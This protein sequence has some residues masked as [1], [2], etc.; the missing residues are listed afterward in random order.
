MRYR[1]RLAL[2]LV[3][4]GLS[5]GLRAHDSI[6]LNGHRL[7][8]RGQSLQTVRALTSATADAEEGS[9]V[10][11]QMSRQVTSR[12]IDELAQQGVKLGDYLGN[13]TYHAL[14][15]KQHARPSRMRRGTIKAIVPLRSEWKVD[16]A[17]T[18]RGGN[19][20]DADLEELLPV[21]IYLAPNA[22]ATHVERMLQEAGCRHVHLNLSL[23]TA[24]AVLPASRLAYVAD[25]P[26][27]LR[28]APADRPNSADNYGGRTLGCGYALSIPATWGGRGLSGKGIRIGVWDANIVSH[29]ELDGRFA[30]QESEIGGDGS[31]RHATH[32][33]GSVLGNG[34]I[35][36]EAQ[37]VAPQAQAWTYNFNTQRNGK[38]EP[39][40]M[41]EARRQFGITLTQNSYG[42][43]LRTSCP[44]YRQFRYR[45]ADYE[46]DRLAHLHPTLTHVLAAGND[47]GSCQ[48]Q[49]QSQHGHPLYG[50]TA[51]RAK[52]VIYV[53]ATDA[54]GVLA[55]F[56][57]CGP[58]DDGRLFPTVVARGVGVL[59]T[60]P[61]GTHRTM[62]GT[63]MACPLVTGHLALLQERYQQL[64]R[65]AEIRSDLLRAVV[66]NTADDAGRP[67]PDF[68]YGY[69][70][71]NAER[72]ARA[73]ES[74]YYTMGK[75]GHKE[76]TTLTL[77][78]PR[79]CSGLRVMLAWNDAASSK[80]VA[81][82]SPVLINDLDMQVLVDRTPYHP[83]V[84][85]HQK[86][87]VE[88]V[89][90]RRVDRLNNQEQITITRDELR[91]AHEVTI[92]IAGRKVVDGQQTYALT[93]WF[94]DDSPRII[95]PGAGAQLC[96]GEKYVARM[97]GSSAWY[98]AWI[99][100]DDGAHYESLGRI[101]GGGSPPGTSPAFTVP[102]NAPTCRTAR[103]KMID[104]RGQEAVSAQPFIIA[105]QVEEPQLISQECG[106]NGWLLRWNG[107]NEAQHGYEVLMAE[108]REGLY[109]SVGH[110]AHAHDVQFDIPAA[111]AQRY[112]HPVFSIAVR[113]PGGGWGKRSQGVLAPEP[114]ALALTGEALPFLEAFV[115]VPSPHFRLTLGDKLQAGYQSN[116]QS[117]ILGA[118]QLILRSLESVQGAAPADH[119]DKGQ[120]GTHLAELRLCQVDLRGIA[121]QE[122]L[123]L[124]MVGQLGS[125]SPKTQ[126]ASR[127]RMLVNGQPVADQFGTVDHTASDGRTNEFLFPLTGGE[128][129][130]LAIQFAGTA[131]GTSFTLSTIAIERVADRPDVSLAALTVPRE[132]SHLG[133]IEGTVRLSNEN[134][135]P[136][137]NI[138]IRCEVDGEWQWGQSIDE[139][140]GKETRTIV[141]PIELGAPPTLGALRRI[142]MTATLEGDTDAQNNAAEATVNEMGDVLTIP[143]SHSE[144]VNGKRVTHDPRRIHVVDGPLMFTDDGGAYGPHSALQISTLKLVPKDPSMRVRIQFTRFRSYP[145]QGTLA[146]YTGGVGDNLS[147][148]GL[149]PRV[150]LSGRHHPMPVTYVSEANDGG[151]T[152][153][154]RSNLSTDEGW[155][156]AVDLVPREN[157]LALID[158]KAQLRG[159]T[160][161][162]EVPIE[163]TVLN[164]WPEAIKGA[165]LI[166][167]DGRQAVAQ[168]QIP[169]LAS[170]R[171]RIVFD[172]K[173][174]MA[175]GS[176]RL[177]TLLLRGEDYDE[178]DN[179]LPLLAAYDRYCLPGPIAKSDA[180]A[181][182]QL[183]L[184]GQQLPMPPAMGHM[185]YHL[186]QRFTVYRTKGA[187]PLAVQLTQRAPANSALGVW[188]DWNDDG[189][190][191]TDEGVIN[192]I[193]PQAD[194]ASVAIDP[195]RWDATGVRRMRIAVGSETELK[196]EPCFAQGLT[197][198]DIRDV[199]LVIEEEPPHAPDDLELT[200]VDAGK[201]GRN[202]SAAQPITIWVRNN[203]DRPYDGTIR[204]VASVDGRKLAEEVIDCTGNPIAANGAEVEYRLQGTADLSAVGRHRLEVVIDEVD[205]KAQKGNNIRS[206]DVHCLRGEANGFYAL[207]MRSLAQET[208]RVDMHEVARRIPR[209]KRGE[210]YTV[211]LLLMLDKA[212]AATLIDSKGF[213]LYTQ[214]GGGSTSSPCR[215]ALNVGGGT[216]LST[217]TEVLTPGRWHHVAVVMRDI[218]P[219]TPAPS[220]TPGSCLVDVYVDGA[221]C[222]LTNQMGREPRL[223]ELQLGSKLDGKLDEFRLWH[224]AVDE[225]ELQ[226]HVHAHWRNPAGELPAGCLMEFSIDEGPGNSISMSGEDVAYIVAGDDEAIRAKT[227]GVWFDAKELISSIR[228]TGQVGEAQQDERNV[229]TVRFPKGTD[230]GHITG[231]V[232]A[233]WPNSSL[234]YRGKPV[235]PSNPFDFNETV[236]IT[237]SHAAIFGQSLLQDVELRFA[238][239]PLDGCELLELRL[240][241]AH[242]PWLTG[243]DVT[244]PIQPRM[245]IAL[246]TTPV[247][248]ELA[249]GVVLTFR[250]SEDAVLLYGDKEYQD[251]QIAVDLREETKLT[252]RAANGTIKTYRLRLAAQQQLEWRL[253]STEFV[254]GDV[255]GKVLAASESG[256]II[257]FTSSNPAVASVANDSLRIG[258]CGT[259]IITAQQRGGGFHGPSN[260]VSHTITVRKRSIQVY[261]AVQP[262]PFGEPVE[263]RF[264]YKTLVSPADAYAL[265]DPMAMGIYKLIDSHGEEVGLSPLLS[266]GTYELKVAKSEAYESTQY[267]ITPKGGTITIEQGAKRL[268]RLT[269][270]NEQGNAIEGAT[271]RI[272]AHRLQSDRKGE[273][274]VALTDGQKYALMVEHPG[275]MTVRD[276]LNVAEDSDTHQRI[277]LRATTIRLEY[278]SGSHGRIAGDRIQHVAAGSNG[279]PVL[280]QADDGYHFARW[281]DGVTD[282][283]RADRQVEQAVHVRAQFEPNRHRLHYS[284]H[285]GGQWI[286]GAPQQNV[287]HGANGDP[288]EVGAQDG[289]YFFAEWSDGALNALRQELNVQHDIDAA[290][291]FG[292]YAT[293]PEVQQ[294]ATELVDGGWY[295]T[296]HGAS[297]TGWTVQPTLPE[298]GYH[299]SGPLAVCQAGNAEK[300]NAGNITTAQ[301]YTPRYRLASTANNIETRCAYLF[302]RTGNETLALEYTVDGSTWV[303]LGD[304]FTAGHN[305]AKTVERTVNSSALAGAVFIQF[306]WTYRFAGQGGYAAISRAYFYESASTRHRYTYVAE[307][308]EGGKFV[309]NGEEVQ[310]QDVAHGQYPQDVQAVA[311][312]GFRFG[313]WVGQKGGATLSPRKPA[314][315]EA[316]YTARFL[317]V[318]L[319]RVQYRAS[320]AEGGHF[321]MAG[322]PVTEQLV[323][324]G[325]LSH[326]VVAV[327]HPG[328]HFV[329]WGD[330]GETNPSRGRMAIQS[331]VTLDGLFV[332]NSHQLVI[333]V[334]RQNE[335]VED[336]TVAIGIAQRTGKDGR[337]LFSLPSGRYAYSVA[338]S[339]RTVHSG[340]V[341]LEDEDTHLRVNLNDGSTIPLRRIIFRVTNGEAPLPHTHVT[342]GG[343][344]LE[345]DE[346]GETQWSLPD[347]TYSYT[348]R[349]DGY[350]D[351]SGTVELKG[352]N[353]RIDIALAVVSYELQYKEPQHVYLSVVDADGHA[354]PSGSR[355]T[356]GT[357]L[358]MT[359]ETDVG[360]RLASL[361]VNGVDRYA[362]LGQD[363]TFSFRMMEATTIETE[364]GRQAGYFPVTI[365]PARGGTIEVRHGRSLVQDGDLL[366]LGATIRIAL[367]PEAG[368][369][370]SGLS[371]NG[372]DRLELVAEGVLQYQIVG[373]SE[374]AAE[375]KRDVPSSAERTEAEGFT[376]SPNPF[377]GTLYVYVPHQE[378]QIRLI[379]AHGV[380]VHEQASQGSHRVALNL[381]CL[382]AGLYLV[383][384][385]GDGFHRCIPVMK[386]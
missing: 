170:G 148:S 285:R 190:F 334:V 258:R 162:G 119:Y 182:G 65:G 237:A 41:D 293:L 268:V 304:E 256:R 97:E 185:Q 201:D 264:Q 306:R 357:L 100:Y 82:G 127:F 3:L 354:R 379:N 247:S 152:L 211:E 245:V 76:S 372:I 195:S 46:M 250:M 310:H 11:V 365:L 73:L 130:S 157:P 40:E 331:D 188:V 337:A 158:G 151:I 109:E 287:E 124:R 205:A 313:E 60:T 52:N 246:P 159:R 352:R 55:P 154:F 240:E 251:G 85:Q 367:T 383:V 28:I 283:P 86:G 163:A 232:L 386:R 83:W 8:L 296:S 184:N 68:Q 312:P 63:S 16:T 311:N 15:R 329:R 236:R 361:R 74:G 300:T 336:V 227:G 282:N 191:S 99:S 132:G 269:V 175:L 18:A 128:E 260:P 126:S 125:I 292:G 51:L 1:Y 255:G 326:E 279:A 384:I 174:R 375:F 167:W 235:G 254:Y 101:P 214:T 238:T 120:N 226:A 141:V 276:E 206:T 96:P 54:Q 129:V 103:L 84:C 98:D 87:Q 278:E 61:L 267:I 213:K 21:A 35:N 317:P 239:I 349:R 366:P 346:Q 347:G 252:V 194:N 93:W 62:D 219:G 381:G 378:A 218:V 6:M 94:D 88:A 248:E 202:L 234:L 294:F 161:Q 14:L 273:V 108:A 220:S 350:T 323:R 315:T 228:L 136:A 31:E 222:A 36:P 133:R 233:T 178:Q 286:A 4:L 90:S 225:A 374:I 149:T 318:D 113:T 373:A 274:T 212:Q 307:P 137:K 72:A 32:V 321:E 351:Q 364:S 371:V 155:I 81:Y 169:E 79:E 123:Q 335:P 291:I 215:L 244:V 284:V 295:A 29:P 179:R 122:P 243:G 131:S 217:Q 262:T 19:P 341:V 333:E 187:T 180:L 143:R 164:R 322:T 348:V 231:E 362:E 249:K 208:Q 330:N 263:W 376:A 106:R 259:C 281:D 53:G 280:A 192:P 319:F 181:I 353:A 145:L 221:R 176:N 112:A 270:V 69:G 12:E 160:S 59:S 369:K 356:H 17:L 229:Y 34:V 165:S 156:A 343:Q 359:T 7:A 2:L 289:G 56:S 200:R 265:P 42:P 78:V 275:H 324:A 37:G 316:R 332:R 118:N 196:G 30:R 71:L 302:K 39:Q 5:V 139:L 33:L 57:S 105:P 363:G 241:Q 67:G 138:R 173:L 142:R 288:V 338:D 64:H 320:A 382:P 10:L 305:S 345:T 339:R 166:L 253:A 257:T 75:L 183:T 193:A 102:A 107:L 358:T 70:I 297:G 197:A 140:Q 242:N 203:S 309:I 198:G 230:K 171:Q 22:W 177:Y 27:V 355:V 209:A 47:G 24:R 150:I 189:E 9:N 271:V 115:V 153:H 66:A 298:A 377:L 91:N 92:Q 210:A 168:Q 134:S 13:G 104:I 328:Y 80:D 48:A 114:Q 216:T 144:I 121:R 224:R 95:A 199:S 277:T 370:L 110:T 314:L 342:L 117:G 23:G 301:L 135:L 20:A 45:H 327:A 266:V 272:G 325:E 50:T 360:Y 49:M 299:S 116:A 204:V 385:T 308:A 340:E 146:V 223:E 89:A 344:Q 303:Q 207:H 368:Y 25:L 77:R 290:A 186:Q 58:Q 43:Q 111:T 147:L 38:S 261:P 44:Y 380:V 172:K 26:W